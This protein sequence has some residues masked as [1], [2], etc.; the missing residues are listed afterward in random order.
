MNNKTSSVIAEFWHEFLKHSSKS[1]IVAA[2]AKIN[3]V[4]EIVGT[5]DEGYHRLSTVFQALELADEL[6][7]SYSEATTIDIVDNVGRGFKV[8]ANE[9]NLVIKAQRALERHCQR[10]LPCDIRLVKTIPA[11]GGLGGGSADAA[12]MLNGLNALYD[13]QL[14]D[15]EMLAIA[16]TIGSDVPFAVMGGT[17]LGTGRG[18]KLTQLPTTLAPYRVVLVTPSEGLSTPTVYAHWDKMA[19]EKRSVAKGKAQRFADLARLPGSL[20]NA[21]LAT[22]SNDLQPAAF[23]LYP[24]LAQIHQA[25]MQA[26]C[27]TAMLCGSGSTMFGLIEPH[28]TP[29]QI[30]AIEQELSKWG[31][32]TVTGI[33]SRSIQP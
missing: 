27:V 5:D 13:L 1:V 4:L 17:A 18:E 6:M 3:L 11:G 30:H 19:P 16:A 14:G 9:N 8:E 7:L 24:E 25:M 2:P 29:D 22:L 21:S 28:L 20:I 32:V 23:E 31:R 15:D 26:G 33:R 10:E 12:A